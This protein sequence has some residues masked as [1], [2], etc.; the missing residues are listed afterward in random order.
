MKLCRSCFSIGNSCFIA[1]TKNN[2]ASQGI[3]SCSNSRMKSLAG[4]EKR[5]ILS[6]TEKRLGSETEK[7]RQKKVRCGCISASMMEYKALFDMI[8]FECVLPVGWGR[9][10]SLSVLHSWGQMWSTVSSSSA[11]E[12][13]T[14][15]RETNKRMWRWQRE[16]S[17]SHM[18]QLGL[19]SLEKRELNG[20]SSMYINNW[21]K[22]AQRT[23]L[24]SF[25]PS[26]GIRSNGH[27]LQHWRFPLNF[28]KYFYCEHD[29]AL[30]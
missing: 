17:T 19:F 23:K 11:R 15:E 14:Y 22:G 1:Q 20:I 24:D 9:W 4:V 21:R 8:W 26:D 5:S 6:G 27:Q 16:E 28:K 12:A 10:S 25:Q 29:R 2:T 7:W 13:W 30:Q 18:R 3:S